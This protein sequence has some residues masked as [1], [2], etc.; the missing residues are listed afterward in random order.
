MV[1]KHCFGLG[2]V[3]GEIDDCPYCDGTGFEDDEDDED[4]EPEEQ[5]AHDGQA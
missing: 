4:D 3:L 1:C 2:H 5:E